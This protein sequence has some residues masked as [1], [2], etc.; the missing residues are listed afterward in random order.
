MNQVS[1]ILTTLLARIIILGLTLLS[2][3][4]LARMLGPEGRGLFALVLLLPELVNNFALLG[5]HEANTIYAGLQPKARQTLVWHSVV[6]A[7]IVGGLIAILGIY[8][9]T[10]GTPWAPA[11]V[12]GPLWLYLL[13]LSLIPCRLIADYWGAILRGMNRILLLNV[14]EVGRKLIEYLRQTE[15]LAKPMIN[16]IPS[17]RLYR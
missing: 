12:R 10:L 11:L 16:G 5:F 3:I 6:L 17:T 15:S 7:G 13:P 4:L 1:N 14:V 9:I 8:F 2:S